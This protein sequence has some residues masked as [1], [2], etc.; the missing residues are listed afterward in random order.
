MF[1]FQF[2]SNK[3][4][5]A[6]SKAFIK[7][8]DGKAGPSANGDQT[9]VNSL[10]ETAYGDKLEYQTINGRKEYNAVTNRRTNVNYLDKS[11]MRFIKLQYFERC[12]AHGKNKK[13]RDARCTD[14]QFNY[15][16]RMCTDNHHHKR[17]YRL[18]NKG[19]KVQLKHRDAVDIKTSSS[20]SS[21]SEESQKKQESD[22]DTST[23]YERKQTPAKSK[24]GISTATKKIDANKME[25][26]SPPS[27]RLRTKA[28]SKLQPVDDFYD[29]EG[30]GDFS[31]E[32]SPYDNENVSSEDCYDDELM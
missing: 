1:F 26:N 28:S 31:A 6:L 12:T 3:E 29:D 30:N 11:I 22:S 7:E 2:A 24:Q 18:K 32:E 27:K 13:E 23:S 10:L 14:S 8:S 5:L 16:V 4:V 25:S 17:Q 15:Y 20:E 9:F 21:S 19:S